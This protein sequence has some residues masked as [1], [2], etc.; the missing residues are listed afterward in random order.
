MR[1]LGF[2]KGNI[3]NLFFSEAFIL[4]VFSS[5]FAVIIAYLA[6]WGADAVSNGAIKYAI[7]QISP[8]NAIAGAVVFILICLLAALAPAAKAAKLDPIVSL[9]SE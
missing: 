3:R 6:E 4:G 8:M 7:V 9:S 1:A 2:T 5:I